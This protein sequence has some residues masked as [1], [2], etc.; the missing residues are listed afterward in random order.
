MS[1]ENK[2]ILI[3]G[4]TGSLGTAIV[5][6]LLKDTKCDQIV[7]FSRDEYKQHRM[8]LRYNNDR[9]RF[10]IGDVRD[11]DRLLRAFKGVDFVVHTAALKQADIIDYNYQ[12][13]VK[14]N[15]DGT[16]NVMEAAID[17]G[18]KKVI[19]ISSDK[20]VEPVNLY[21]ATKL[22]GEQIMQSGNIYSA[23]KTQFQILRSGNFIN[24]R[25]S[26]TE[27]LW[28]LKQ[29][30]IKEVPLV[31]ENMER[32]WVNMGEVAD[33]IIVNLNLTTTDTVVPMMYLETVV[34][35]ARRIIPNCKFVKI[36]RFGMEKLD[37]K[38]W[39]PYECKF[40]RVILHIM[41]EEYLSDYKPVD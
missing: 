3:T 19:F 15:I 5:D 7:I 2:R 38:L 18:I 35:I 20:A 40:D 6:K 21:G 31:D 25:G 8:R 22:V 27:M 24:S 39:Q 29:H 37:E 17:C 11:K 32:Y 36:N 1:F 34:N 30:G 12:E 33:L 14:T 10:M 13:A 23:G 26:F 9:L 4:G 41:P 16:N 28:R